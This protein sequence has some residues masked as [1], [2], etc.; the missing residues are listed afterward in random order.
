MYHLQHV[1]SL[2]DVLILKKQRV[3]LS[4]VI[5]KLAVYSKAASESR[6][7]F[8]KAEYTH[9]F[10]VFIDIYVWKFIIHLPRVQIS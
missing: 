3:Y 2:Y 5:L 8:I 9:R 7:Q 4:K 6:V 1:S 10:F